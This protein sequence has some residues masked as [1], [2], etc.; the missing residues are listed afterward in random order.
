MTEVFRLHRRSRLGLWKR[1]MASTVFWAF[2]LPITI[3]L[4]A[5]IHPVA[6]AGFLAYFLQLFRIALGR[7]ATSAQ[8]WTCASFLMLAKFPEFQ[9]ILKFCWHQLRHPFITSTES[10]RS[11][12]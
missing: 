12:L 10:E 6:L 2:L 4:S 11:Y 5:L 1:E 3:C 9:G 8:A 7:G